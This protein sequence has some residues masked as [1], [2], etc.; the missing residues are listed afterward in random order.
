MTFTIRRPRPAELAPRGDLVVAAYD[1]IGANEDDD[2]YVPV[3]RDVARRDREA[4]VLAAVDDETGAL[5]GCVTYAPD[6]S[7]P[8]AEELRE[9]EA[10]IRMLAVAPGAQGRGVGTA[11][12]AACVER[13]RADGRTAIFL[14]SLPI[15]VAAQRIYA[16]LG[17][18]RVPERDWPID[19][20]LL[21]G[22]VL[23]LR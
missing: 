17:F 10:T 9:G 7:N 1:A 19:D 11:L 22:F 23:E 8:W 16:R 18:R 6:G 21:L 3:L 15:M 14:H 20:F 2:E 13:A 5:L 4:A 12:T